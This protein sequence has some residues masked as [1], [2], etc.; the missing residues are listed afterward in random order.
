MVP[1]LS[2]GDQPPSMKHNS[3]SRRGSLSFMAYS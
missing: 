1:P 3:R 2:A